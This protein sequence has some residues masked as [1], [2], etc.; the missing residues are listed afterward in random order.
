MWMSCGTSYSKD[1][2]FFYKYKD[3][4]TSS[5]EVVNVEEEVKITGFK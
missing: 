4:D 5:K 3:E 2:W 1:Y